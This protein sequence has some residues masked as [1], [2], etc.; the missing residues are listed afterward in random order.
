MMNIIDNK[1]STIVLTILY[2]ILSFPF[3]YSG[4]GNSADHTGIYA[5]NQFGISNY[6]FGSELYFSYGPLGFLSFPMMIKNNIVIG[7]IFYMVI[8]LSQLYFWI[9]IFKK[10]YTN[11][12]IIYANLFMVL[13][14]KLSSSS[15]Y[16]LC[17]CIFLSLIVLW[18]D[19]NRYALFFAIILSTSLFF[20]KFSAAIA[21]Y[22]TIFLYVI[23]RYMVSKRWYPNILLISIIPLSIVLYL[24]YNPSIY[25]FW[26]YI[27]TAAYI[28]SGYSIAMSL[29]NLNLYVA[30]GILL[31]VFYTGIMFLLFY[32]NSVKNA[33]LMLWFTPALFTYYKHG[34]VRA[35]AHLYNAILG[36]IS[37]FSIIILAIDYDEISKILKGKRSFSNT[38]ISL[39]SG[40]L[41]IPVLCYDFSINPLIYTKDKISQIPFKLGQIMNKEHQFDGLHIVP[42]KFVN[43]IGM[44]T[45]T[46]FSTEAA[47]LAQYN[48]NYVPLPTI[49]PFMAYTPELDKILSNFF[50]SNSA[51]QYII[52][53]FW[54]IDD[55]IPL[56][57]TP[58]SWKSVIQNYSFVEYDETTN[59]FLLR[60]ENIKENKTVVEEITGTAETDSI[61]NV[62][63]FSEIFVDFE[64]NQR[65][66]LVKLFW[67]IDPVNINIRYIDGTER[68][69]RIIP[70]NLTNGLCISI[71]P[72]D[73]ETVIS[74]FSNKGTP[75]IQ[76][77]TFSGSGLKYYK[78][79]LKVRGIIC[80]N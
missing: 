8:F 64:L 1:Y 46:T 48:M 63:D 18:K 28:S 20:I 60:K 53:N 6:K 35:D 65:G 76:E 34:F 62:E 24:I 3:I 23:A 40:V 19:N 69:G 26:M 54:T 31:I 52:L 77:I 10:N 72:Y 75:Q 13:L 55:R 67:K 56:M 41:I 71:L 78:E 33:F 4:F 42:E 27:K 79:Q 70:E 25:S 12:T 80:R 11:S 14:S 36:V 5:L 58:A 9:T 37:I 49:H 44:D 66:K 15:D 59:W 30:W 2:G 68:T 73:K 22:L 16:Y 21:V 57:D 47:Y 45:V 43:I 38:F 29:P 39:V 17:Y 50:V 32:K 61:I 7:F 74:T 51:P